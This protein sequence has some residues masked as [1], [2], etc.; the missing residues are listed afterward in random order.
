MSKRLLYLI[1]C[2]IGGVI[3]LIA[4]ATIG[5]FW[6]NPSTIQVSE[7]KP[8]TRPLP[9]N[10]F[11]RNQDDYAS[12]K[13]VL[14][15]SFGTPPMQLP[16]LRPLLIFYGPSDR[17]DIS[18]DSTVLYFALANGK[19][20]GSIAPGGKLY[21][22]YDQN[23]TPPQ[24]IFSPQNKPTSLWIETDVKGKESNI[25]VGMVDEN[26]KIVLNPSSNHEFTLQE[27]EFTRTAGSPPWEIGKW[28]VDGTLLARQKARWFGE[29]IFLEQHGGEEFADYINKERVDFAEGEESYSVY[30]GAGSI[31]IWKDERWQMA[32]PATHTQGF[33]LLQVKKVDERLLTFELWDNE[34]KHKITL[35]LL[36]SKEPW[37]PQQIEQDFKFVATRTRSQFVFEIQ[38]QR[39]ILRPNDWLILTDKGWEVIDTEEE[40]D[41]YVDRKLVGPMFVFNGM[42]KVDDKQI[43]LGSLYNA[44]RTEVE[45]V[46]L[47][48]PQSN[49]NVINIPKEKLQESSHDDAFGSDYFQRFHNS[50]EED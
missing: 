14:R 19:S 48:A 28:R 46:E 15:L 10:A 5:Y 47:A 7:E 22:M 4:L 21:L 44:T 35:N 36:K 43:L 9:T 3:L 11:A 26:N 42:V 41:A 25:K 30:V 2:G 50:I 23:S 31:L 20:I 13:E 45:K 1:N 6:A 49:I 24:Y 40:I 12:V 32:T 34:G 38:N 8:Q 18:K 17:P 37:A 33:P 29:D 39:T 16:N 27:R